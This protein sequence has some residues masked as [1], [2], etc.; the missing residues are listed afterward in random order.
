MGMRGRMFMLKAKCHFK[1]LILTAWVLLLGGVCPAGFANDPAEFKEQKTSL[2]RDIFDNNIY[3][4]SV[5]YLHLDRLYRA[6]FRKALRSSNVNLFDEVPDDTVF[7]TNRHA[8]K[9]LSLEELERGPHETDGMDTSGK[10][11]VVKG[12]FEGLH[13]GFFARDAR[14]DLYLLK[15]DPVD[16]LE[17]ATGAEVIASRFYHAFGYNVPQYTIE[18]F[19][20]EQL[21]PAPDATTYD[22]TGFK[23]P[24]TKE[25]LEEYMLFIPQTADG[26]YRASASKILKGQAKGYF[27]FH[28]RRRENTAD[29]VDHRVRRDIRALQV[30]ASWLNNYDQR[31]G[32]TLDMVVEENGQK[33]LKH[34]LIDFNGAFGSGTEEAKPPMYAYEHMI[35]YGEATKAFLALGFWEK[36]WQKRWREA[37]EEFTQPP[38]IGYFDSKRFDPGRFKTQLPYYAFK[39]LTRAD[40]FWAAKII[41]SFTDEEIRTLVKTGEYTDSQDSDYIAKTLIERRDIVGRYWFAQSNPLDEF[42]R[43]DNKLVFKDLAVMYGFEQAAGTTYHVTVKGAHGKKRKAIT[44]LTVSE[45]AVALEADW[46]SQ[47]DGVDLWI[48]TARQGSA[49]LSPYVLISV[50]QQGV[51]RIEHED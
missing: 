35:D 19:S 26:K 16:N 46:F 21:E 23:K 8:R 9:R 40:A 31:D 4:E 34:Y 10:L 38:A 22:D 36:P 43:Q 11:T 50:N 51:S 5:N 41:M 3:Y 32:N 45:P 13:P 24:L 15:F 37:G 29:P 49:A 28:G 27:A 39:D 42:D 44:S 6:V 14:G 47:H 7:F 17:L 30:F 12:K 33:I 48:R 1:P 18:T 25:K 2:Y 20:L